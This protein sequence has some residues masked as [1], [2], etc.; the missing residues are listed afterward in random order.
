MHRLALGLILATA[1]AAPAWAEAPGARQLT[2]DQKGYI[3]YDQCMMHA[4]IRASHTD[5]KDDEIFDMSKAAC[6]STRAAVILGQEN[7]AE[8]LAAL[9][10]ADADKSARFPAWIKG[11]RARRAVYDARPATPA[12][13]PPR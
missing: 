12:A 4:A 13:T 10:A 11:V 2:P 5:A 8:F 3:V 1:V 9:D 6:A 7:N